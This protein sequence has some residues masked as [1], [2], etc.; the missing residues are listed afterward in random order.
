MS[1]LHAE[2]WDTGT[3]LHGYV[4]HAA[5]PQGVVLLQHGFGE[6]AERYVT[7]YSELVPALLAAGFTVHALDLEGHG[8]SPGRRAV[9]DAR[10]AVEQHLQARRELRRR[11]LPVFLFGHSLGGLVTASSAAT[12]PAGTAGV[13]L[14]GAAFLPGRGTALRL[15]SR[16][17]AAVA[18]RLGT[19]RLPPAG[20]TQS[21]AILERVAEDALMFRGAMPARLGAS[22][23]DVA[24][25]AWPR[26]R[27]WQLPVLVVHGTADTYTEPEGSRLFFD[28]IP[29]RDKTLHLVEGGYHETLND[30]DGARVATL[31]VEWLQARLTLPL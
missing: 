5:Q 31:V 1:E 14:S 21:A 28:T 6:H 19:V 11:A 18:P 4:W 27:A 25:D 29:A 13:V 15:L 16:A 3:G 2:T 10:L 7:Q 20:M 9:T 24:A 8:R 26:Y 17:V 22:M 23:L 30:P 12:D